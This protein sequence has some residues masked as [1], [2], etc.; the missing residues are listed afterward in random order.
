MIAGDLGGW[1]VFLSAALFPVVIW[2]WAFVVFEY[3]LGEIIHEIFIVRTILRM[4]FFSNHRL[5]LRLRVSKI[6][7]NCAVE[8]KGLTRASS[9]PAQVI[10]LTPAKISHLSWREQP[11]AEVTRK[12]FLRAGRAHRKSRQS[13]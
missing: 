8:V 12:L 1:P 9:Q 13:R 10:V 5:L 3:P 7:A 2:C 6:M 4:S 11:Y